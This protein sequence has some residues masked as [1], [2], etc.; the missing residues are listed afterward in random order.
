M[1]DAALSPPPIAV[2]VPRVPAWL[3]APALLAIVA[4]CVALPLFTYTAVL[5][6]F[7]FAHVVSEIRYVDWRFGSRLK[8]GLALWLSGP[9][10]VAVTARLAGTLRWLPAELATTIELAAGAALL[11]V[12]LRVLQRRRVL[13]AILAAAMLAAALAAPILTLLA[14]AV[15]HNLTPVAFLAEATVGAQRRR[16][17]ALG[18]T[19]FVGLPLLIATGL[20]YALLTQAGLAAPEFSLFDGG[21]LAANL[22]AYIPGALHASA[23][24]QHAFSGAVFAQCLHYAAVIWL[25]PRLIPAT[26]I[27][28]TGL[29]RWPSARLFGIALA[30]ASAALAA[31]YAIDF[32]AA[33]R[34]YSLAA[35]LHAWIEIPIL[36]LA[37]EGV[38]GR[39]SSAT[40]PPRTTPD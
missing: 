3:A 5:A 16:A 6:L 11:A 34:L 20:P 22:G 12:L 28:R 19:L 17:V 29:L 1:T 37:L 35:L 39:R 2:R 13:A 40:G 23:F 8:G 15:L 24:A 31:G 30:A 26:G 7:G 10:L 4:A 25:L 38:T 36:V 14:L 33:R 9:L 21:P 27:E 18:L 32:D